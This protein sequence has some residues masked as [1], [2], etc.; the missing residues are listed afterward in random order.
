MQQQWTSKV[1][2]KTLYSIFRWVRRDL[3][4]ERE[5]GWTVFPH[6]DVAAARAVSE[7]V[8]TERVRAGFALRH[9]AKL[10]RVWR[11]ME[12]EPRAMPWELAI[13]LKAARWRREGL[14]LPEPEP[15]VLPPAMTEKVHSLYA[16]ES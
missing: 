6:P 4:E 9:A 1:Q 12:I 15:E 5:D 3:A 10:P 13:E 11:D 2:W 7:A 14:M 8:V 16:A